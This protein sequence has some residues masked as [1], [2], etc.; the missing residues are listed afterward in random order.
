MLSLESHE[1]SVSQPS[2]RCSIELGIASGFQP[3]FHADFHAL[4]ID[5]VSLCLDTDVSRM[6]D[7]KPGHIALNVEYAKAG[8]RCLQLSSIHPLKS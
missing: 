5:I 1:L 6:V 2:A 3:D 4:M 7:T 8:H